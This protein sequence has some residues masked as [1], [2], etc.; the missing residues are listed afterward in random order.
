MSY[1]LA[2]S[3]KLAIKKGGNKRSNRKLSKVAKASTKGGGTSSRKASNGSGNSGRGRRLELP[4]M[5]PCILQWG[6]N[7]LVWPLFIIAVSYG[8][9]YVYRTVTTHE[10]F[11]L[12]EIEVSGNRRLTSAEV[13]RAGDVYLGMNTLHLAMHEV[14]SNLLANPWVESAVVARELP[15]TFRLEVTERIPHWWVQRDDGLYYA[16]EQGRI[17]APV[18]PRG[19]TSLP[20]IHLEDADGSMLAVCNRLRQ[21]ADAGKLPF[22][23][24][25]VG[26]LRL[27]QGGGVELHLE[28]AGITLSM[29]SS[30]VT[31][32]LSKLQAVWDDLQRRNELLNVAAIRLAGDKLWVEWADA[33]PR[34][35][36]S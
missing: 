35:T 1:T 33:T 3:S 4:S 23:M 10:Y 21:L 7:F 15:A 26:W 25:E 31:Q 16:D 29:E 12:R 30:N 18:E 24:Q 9:L 17:I 8:C 27:S 22:T 2:S 20:L 13:M 28:A 36:V 6:V 5:G 19:F 11:T 34:K 14:R 32:Q